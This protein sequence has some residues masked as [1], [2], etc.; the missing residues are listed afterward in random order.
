[1]GSMGKS[2]AVRAV[3]VGPDGSYWIGVRTLDD[4][5]IQ[6]GSGN[7]RSND[8]GPLAFAKRRSLAD[9]NM[10][11]DDLRAFRAGLDDLLD[12][13]TERRKRGGMG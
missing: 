10:S 11:L 2:F 7:G 13:A 9:S 1:M 3:T 8:T 12:E 4:G 5:T 6:Y